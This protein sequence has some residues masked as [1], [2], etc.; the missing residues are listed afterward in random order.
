MEER[1]N[2]RK[3]KEIEEADPKFFVYYT[4]ETKQVDIP[5][6]TLTHLRVDSFVR[7]IPEYAFK[8][9][10]ALVQVQLPETLT[11]IGKGAFEGCFRLQCVQFFTITGGS[12]IEI[13][14]CTINTPPDWEDGMILFPENAKLQIDEGA[15]NACYSL[16]V[17]LCS[18]STTLSQASFTNCHGLISVELPEGRLHLIDNGDW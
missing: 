11:R 18:V 6:A 14:P 2:D 12:S 8:C 9:C 10:H 16:K 7:E 15:F 13:F 4:S 3:Q 5:K 1:N 17:I